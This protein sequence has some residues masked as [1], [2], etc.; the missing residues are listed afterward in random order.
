MQIRPEV[1]LAAALALPAGAFAQQTPVAPKSVKTQKLTAPPS[2]SK[3]MVEPAPDGTLLIDWDLVTELA[4][5]D[6]DPQRAEI[7]RIMLAI[8]DGRWR[9]MPH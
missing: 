3:T 5:G 9:S 4:A 2:Y 8:R 1:L 6:A 7:A